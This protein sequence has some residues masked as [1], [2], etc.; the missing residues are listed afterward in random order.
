MYLTKSEF[1]NILEIILKE[2]VRLL[3]EQHELTQEFNLND[4][5]PN[6][7]RIE[8]I[9]KMLIELDKVVEGTQNYIKL[10]K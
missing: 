3:N 9:K 6:E 10:L 1:Q 4:F 7:Q 2:C 5:N 8:Q